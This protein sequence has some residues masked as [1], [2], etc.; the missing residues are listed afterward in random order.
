MFDLRKFS[1]EDMTQIG[2][3]WRNLGAAAG[4][5]PAAAEHIV[6]YVQNQLIDGESGEPVCLLTNLYITVRGKALS[7]A[8]REIALKKLSDSTISLSQLWCLR[9]IAS[10]GMPAANEFAIA[11]PDPQVI[12]IPNAQSVAQYPLFEQLLSQMGI[13]AEYLIQ[14]DPT[15]TL[16][17][18]ASPLNIFL[19]P[20]LEKTPQLLRPNTI[21]IP[22]ETHSLFGI[23]G[24]LPSGQFFFLLMFSKIEMKHE[25]VEL[26]KP[27]A[28]SL[29]L[30][31]LPYVNQ[32][33]VAL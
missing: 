1:L 4:G 14:D 32:T 15:L 7:P 30:A 24:M 12:P 33:V 2:R 28:L 16:E 9:L 8:L 23:G 26:F 6:R 5:I 29:K 22:Q 25:M 31:L 21:L 19:I 13:S 20:N 27:L 17:L 18:A 11:T 3:D 10:A